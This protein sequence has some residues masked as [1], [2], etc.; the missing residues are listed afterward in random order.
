M[1]NLAIHLL[2]M[3]SFVADALCTPRE[4]RSMLGRSNY[5]VATAIVLIADPLS[6]TYVQ[7]VI[8]RSGDHQDVLVVYGLALSC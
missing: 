8:A 2:F 7:S 5:Q 3:A 6:P 4:F 1:S